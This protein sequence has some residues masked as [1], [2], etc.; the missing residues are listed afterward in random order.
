MCRQPFVPENWSAW[1]PQDSLGDDITQTYKVIPGGTPV[2]HYRIV[3][4][5]G[6]GGMGEVY[7]AEDTQR[8]RHVALKFLAP[9]L[10]SDEACRARFRQEA[11]S[12]AQLSHPNII[13][14]HEVGDFRG[15][16]YFVMEYVAGESL[17]RYASTNQGLPIARALTIA[18]E[19]GLGLAAAHEQGIIHRDLKPS[20]I[21]IDA[22]GQARIVDFGLASLASGPVAANSGTITG[23]AAYMSPE[24]VQ[25]EEIDTRSD[26]FSLGVVLY[27]LIAG[28]HPF[29]RGSEPATFQA[30]ID[31]DFEPLTAFRLDVSDDL[32]RVVSRLL[33]SDRNQRYQSAGDLVADLESLLGTM[34]VPDTQAAGQAREPAPSIAVLPF[35]NLSADEKQDYFC[36]GMAEEIINALTKVRGLRVAA[37]ASAFR[38]KLGDDDIRE[39]GKKL[40]VRT[41]L[42]GSVRKAGDR[43]RISLQLIDVASGYHLWS[44]RY[45]RELVD[46]FAVQDEI[47]ENIVRALRLILSDDERRAIATPVAADIEA[48]DF[49][50]RGRRYFHQGRKKSLEFARQMFTRAIDIDPNYAVAYA[51]VADCC[52]LLVHW[53]G[54]SSEANIDQADRASRKALQLDQGLAEAHQARG[55]AL[56]LMNRHEEADR[57]FETAIQLDPN[58]FG[59]HYFYARSC[60]Q[61]GQFD[62]AVQLFEDAC[63]IRDEFEAQFFAAQT[64]AAMGR[65]DRA[66]EAYQKAV[67]AVDKHLE[68]NPDNARAVT[69]GA[70]SLCRLGEPEKGLQWAERAVAIDPD[71]AGI[72]YNVA[73]LYALEGHKDRAFECLQDAV[74]AGFA[75]K[76]WVENDPDLNSLRDDPRFK[77]LKWR[78]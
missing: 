37:R 42:K 76:D 9:R 53:Y 29:K 38:F 20:N 2:S 6:L 34:K 43:L 54:E 5:I 15:R 56:W 68:L 25:G 60:F 31:A 21:L 40:N 45:D 52:S 65:E 8:G 36:E 10:S 12:A 14:T 66:R 70:V 46:V 39:I 55:F 16:P 41:L 62:K 67:Q 72:K 64:Y 26:L 23:T 32:Q 57:E 51:G 27:E 47:A 13:T 19:V 18:V 33:T 7:L 73:C 71:D 3:R 63:R 61:R 48:Y 11:R 30:I 24:Q 58:N 4:R 74:R 49:Y 28:K 77:A 1:V 75:H 78:E 50:L 22:D 17:R 35:A 69:M 44:E 59:A